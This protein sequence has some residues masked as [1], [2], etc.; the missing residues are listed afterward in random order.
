MDP[1]SYTL[2]ALKEKLRARKLSTAGSK[3]EL[4]ARLAEV[5][6]EG[7][8]MYE[9]DGNEHVRTEYAGHIGNASGARAQQIPNIYQR[10]AEVYKRE[11]EVA[12][13]EL[14]L[15]RRELELLRG[16]READRVRERQGQAS[17]GDIANMEANMEGHAI[18][19]RAN[20]AAIAE[21]LIR[22]EGKSDNYDVWERQ[23]KLLRTTYHMNDDITRVMIGM[24]LKDKALEWLYSKPEHIEMPIDELFNEMRSMYQSRQSKLTLRRTFE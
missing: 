10:E 12:E 24:R 23:A 8:W 2:V 9:E 18:R 7:M 19:G 16:N 3:G 15:V 13:R 6:P 11:K 5:D 20:V 17:E 4:I 21:L 14:A 1:S 22:F